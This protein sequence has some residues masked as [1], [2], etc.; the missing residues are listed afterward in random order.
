VDPDPYTYVF[1]LPGSVIIL[2]GSEYGPNLDPDPNP[3]FI[4]Q[5]ELEKH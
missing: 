3:Y 5:K 2:Y 1:G 4:L